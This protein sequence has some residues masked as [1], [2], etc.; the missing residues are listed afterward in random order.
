MPVLS[1]PWA[2]NP[3][4]KTTILP[5]V[6]CSAFFFWFSGPAAADFFAWS[7][8]TSGSW[9]D[10][11]KWTPTGVP[12]AADDAGIGATGAAYTVTVDSATAVSNLGLGTGA[13]L[14]GNV[15]ITVG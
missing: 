10:P 1:S 15:T 5:T 7:T 13:T 8:A 6:L 14:G 9:F 4:M 2:R 12:G 3:I 11:S